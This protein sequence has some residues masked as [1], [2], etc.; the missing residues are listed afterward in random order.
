MLIRRKRITHNICIRT[1]L[2]RYCNFPFSVISM[3][4]MTY[5]HV[6]IEHARPYRPRPVLY[7]LS[8]NRK[9]CGP[10]ERGYSY[11]VY[12]SLIESSPSQRQSADW[13]KTNQLDACTPYD[14]I[15]C[16]LHCWG[17]L[18]YFIALNPEGSARIIIY[19]L[20]SYV[21]S[22]RLRFHT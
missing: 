16:Y 21:A 1:E 20:A 12:V 18:N 4:I 19:D 14:V 2:Y 8:C 11:V 13:L 5:D 3:W 9:S 17:I 10:G 22:F 15:S 7:R 6:T